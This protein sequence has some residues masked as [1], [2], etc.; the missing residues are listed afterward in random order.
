VGA[1]VRIRLGTTFRGHDL[2]SGPDGELDG[3]GPQEPAAEH[4]SGGVRRPRRDRQP[5]PQ[6]EAAG[7][8]AGER[9][10]DV[11]RG[12]ERGEKI[13]AQAQ[14]F[15]HPIRPTIGAEVVE[16]GGRGV[17]GLGGYLPREAQPEPVLGLERPPGGR[18]RVGLVVAQP[19]ETRP[20]HADGG[21]VGESPAGVLVEFPVRFELPGGA[22]V[23]PEDGWSQRAPAFV[24]EDDA[25]H[26]TRE[27]ERHNPRAVGPDGGLRGLDDGVP[28]LLRGGL[29]PSR[30]RRPDGVGSRA[31]AQNA[32]VFAHQEGFDGASAEIQ[33]DQH[34]A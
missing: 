16:Q 25:M 26:L 9:P 18:A 7:G 22:G 23:G 19:Q 12:D 29:G 28:P 34:A 32:A 27:P 14:S 6:P 20:G 2:A 33:A 31:F 13:R 15:D 17:G 30:S 10:G 8:I 4:R 11:G 21:R 5:G 3:P 24:G 1:L